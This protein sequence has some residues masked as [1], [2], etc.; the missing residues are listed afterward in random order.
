MRLQCIKTDKNG[1]KYLDTEF[2]Y[3]HYTIGKFIGKIK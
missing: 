2:D 3:F 1:Y